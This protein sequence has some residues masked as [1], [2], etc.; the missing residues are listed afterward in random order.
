M[1]NADAYCDTLL[2]QQWTC[3]RCQSTADDHGSEAIKVRASPSRPSRPSTTPARRAPPEFAS[4]STLTVPGPVPSVLR[5]SS[6]AAIRCEQ[7][8][9]DCGTARSGIN[10]RR[11]QLISA[12]RGLLH[13]L[14]ALLVHDD[15]ADREG[16]AASAEHR[17][18]PLNA[19]QG[20]VR[21]CRLAA[22]WLRTVPGRVRARCEP[23]I[24]PPDW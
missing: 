23:L 3:T 22:R 2:T 24:S 17:H 16:V 15:E 7:P 11:G 12:G 8:H 20:T 4:I 18:R 19:N 9:I 13:D 21:D 10:R 14:D 1:L 5:Q 6:R